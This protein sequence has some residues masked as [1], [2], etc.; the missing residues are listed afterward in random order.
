MRRLKVSNSPEEKISVPILVWFR[1]NAGDYNFESNLQFDEILSD[2]EFKNL[3]LDK[4]WD[5]V[6][7]NLKDLIKDYLRFYQSTDSYPAYV[8]SPKPDIIVQKERTLMEYT[9]TL[10]EEEL[11]LVLL[12][13]VPNRELQ[14]KIKDQSWKQNKISA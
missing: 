5:L 11:G 10:T 6:A 9:I 7:P 2:D 12:A 4:L 8:W 14:Q 1:D 3:D 13:L